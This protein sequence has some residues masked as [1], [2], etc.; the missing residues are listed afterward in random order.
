MLS[1]SCDRIPP[2]VVQ[3]IVF[4]QKTFSPFD[5]LGKIKV[6]SGNE[7]KLIAVHEVVIDPQLEQDVQEDYVASMVLDSKARRIEIEYESG[8]RFALNVD[9]FAVEGL[10]PNRSHSR[11]DDTPDDDGSTSCCFGR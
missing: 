3:P 9:S 7:E 2:P 4:E 5:G 6:S 11:R 8:A 1:V 10:S